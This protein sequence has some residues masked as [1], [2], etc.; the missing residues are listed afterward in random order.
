MKHHPKQFEN[1]SRRVPSAETLADIGSLSGTVDDLILKYRDFYKYAFGALF[2][3]LV[4][5]TWLEHQYTYKG[6]SRGKPG[7][8][9]L[10]PNQV[11][12]YFMR[13]MVGRSQK[14]LTD[15]IILT[16]IVSYFPVFFPKFYE[17]NP[18]EESGYYKFP[19][20]NISIDHMAFVYQCDERLDMLAHAEKMA[21]SYGVFRDWVINHVSCGFPGKYIN[22]YSHNTSYMRKI[23]AVHRIYNRHR[24]YE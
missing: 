13:H 11:Y 4:K 21:M 3:L 22:T 16:G 18:F 19:Y 12:G 17:H 20:E 15:G 5:Q 7:E 9:G 24:H 23:G 14:P 10:Y 2:D 6:L 8:Q 1:I